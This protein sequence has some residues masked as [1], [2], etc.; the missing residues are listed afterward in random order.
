MLDDHNV[1]ILSQLFNVPKTREFARYYYDRIKPQLTVWAPSS[2]PRWSEKPYTLRLE[3]F[4]QTGGTPYRV[5]TSAG[6]YDVEIELMDASY[7]DE[8]GLEVRHKLMFFNPKHIEEFQQKKTDFK[9]YCCLI[10][11]YPE[12]KMAELR[13]VNSYTPCFDATGLK[14]GK[15]VIKVAIKYCR[16]YREQLGIER[17]ELGDN[18]TYYCDRPTKQ[19]GIKLLLSRQLL[20]KYP[21]YFQFGFRPSPKICRRI[22]YNL[23]LMKSKVTGDCFDNRSGLLEFLEMCKID[24]MDLLEYVRAN[25][26]QALSTTLKYISSQFC[27]DYS[28]FYSDLY[29]ELKLLEWPGWDDVYTLNL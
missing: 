7:Y 27:E 25:S 10:M 29:K 11:I 18:A 16:K 12:D 24:N 15:L 20:G 8:A 6:S 21:Y 3:R 14:S 5:R 17:L 4:S 19:Y 26:S 9:K 23:D 2:D 13:D 1:K 28:T 22:E